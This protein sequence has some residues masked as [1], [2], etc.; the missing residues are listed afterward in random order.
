MAIDL[1]AYKQK[2]KQIQ[3]DKALSAKQTS[4]KNTDQQTISQFKAMD[5]PTMSI[6]NSIMPN[7]KSTPKPSETSTQKPLSFADTFKQAARD[8]KRN[9][10]VDIDQLEE[11]LDNATTEQDIEKVQTNF[12]RL[13]SAIQEKLHKKLQGPKEALKALYEHPTYKHYNF[14]LKFTKDFEDAKKQY[15]SEIQ[16]PGLKHLYTQINNRDTGINIEQKISEYKSK[17]DKFSQKMNLLFHSLNEKEN[18][19]DKQR[20]FVNYKNT[21]NYFMKT[22]PEMAFLF[23]IIPENIQDLDKAERGEIL[24][25]AYIEAAK[26]SNEIGLGLNPSDKFFLEQLETYAGTKKDIDEYPTKKT[27]WRK[28]PTEDF[29]KGRKE[30]IPFI[31]DEIKKYEVAIN[32]IKVEY[33]NEIRPFI[34]DLSKKIAKKKAEIRSNTLATNIPT[35]SR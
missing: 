4:E 8:F 24:E 29:R 7:F 15:T 14:A 2:A 27:R 6:G 17:K 13:T 5:K 34:A 21:K 11:D 33:F 28:D 30:E 10:E 16:D 25:K 18:S 19:P 35:E 1:N 9:R 32:N 3:Q 23:D 26:R 22:Y 20:S 12:N 31:A